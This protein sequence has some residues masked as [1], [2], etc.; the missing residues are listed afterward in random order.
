VEITGTIKVPAKFA[1]APSPMTFVALGDCLAPSPHIVGYG[2]S[3][4]GRFF[5]EVFVP[6]SSDLTLCAASEPAPGKPSTLYGKATTPIHA[7]GTGEL[8]FNNFVVEL[9]P[10]PPKT[11]EH[12]SAR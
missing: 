10:G 12:R 11:F 2:G 1:K 9:A 5:V 6:W 8:E 7:E 3:T 4:N